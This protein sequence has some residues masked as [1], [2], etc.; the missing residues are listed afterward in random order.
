MISEFEDFCLWMYVV[1]DELWPRVAPLC[2]RPGPAPVCS[3]SE[4]VTMVLVG[5][6][7]GW[8]QE[9]DLVRAWRARRD[10]FPVVPERSRF[11]RR[12]RALAPA[13]N[14]L[15][16]LTLRLLDLATDRQC[17]I[18]SLPVPALSFHLVPSSPAVGTWKAH[19]AAFG[20]VTTKKQTIFGYKLQLLVTLNGVILDF[21][22]APANVNDLEAGAELLAKHRD[23]LV[24]GDKGY[25]SAPVAAELLAEADLT[26]LTVPRKNQRVQLPPALAALHT[27]WRQIVE[28]VNGQLADLLHIEENHAHSFDGLC[29][30]LYSKLTAHTLAVYLNRLL[31]NPDCLHLKALAFPN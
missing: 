31:G 26:L 11:N 30:R 22:L 28:T 4:L 8:D 21:L 7:R 2:E 19:G 29:A 14:A 25:L 16:R 1:V 5:E 3:D 18:D 27:R 20:K 13:I 12:R 10:L 23:L 6:C 24:L 15:R 9:T 17:A